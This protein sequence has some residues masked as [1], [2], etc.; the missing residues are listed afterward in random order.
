[1]S[2]SVKEFK[3]GF[4]FDIFANGGF[5]QN[6]IVYNL[7]AKYTLYSNI[8]QDLKA[9]G[10]DLT[11]IEFNELE[12]NSL[13]LGFDNYLPPSIQYKISELI[14]LRIYKLFKKGFYDR[15]IL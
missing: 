1:M 9:V 10:K 13:Y 5:L 8:L 11:Q 6:V 12:K 3:D 2:Y 14:Y 4:S 15:Y 7:N